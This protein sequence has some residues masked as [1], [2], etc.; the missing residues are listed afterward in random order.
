MRL[1]SLPSSIA[2]V[3]CY[4]DNLRV[5]ALEV[6]AVEDIFMLVTAHLDQIKALLVRPV[7]LQASSGPAY[8]R[9]NTP[10]RKALS[11]VSACLR[12]FLTV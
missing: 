4:A 7:T 12:R 6:R 9:I 10:T 5:I 1:S 3:T 11:C 2:A 8:G